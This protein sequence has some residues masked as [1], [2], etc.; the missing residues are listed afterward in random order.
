MKQI[1]AFLFCLTCSLA[2]DKIPFD[3]DVSIAPLKNGVEVWIRPHPVPSR[4][5]AC[6]V[7]AKHPLE[8]VPQIFS[9]NCP[10]DAFEEELPGFVEDCQ[11]EILHE[12]QC[13]IA[14]IV[15][16]D[17]KKDELRDFLADAFEIFPDRVP[18]LDAQIVSVTPSN[19]AGQFCVSL[20][21]PT[22]FQEIMTDQ[23]LKELWVLYLLQSIIEEKFRKTVKEGEGQWIQ[24]S[25]AKYILP[26]ANT[27]ARIRQMAGH[28]PLAGLKGFLGA[29]T[30]LK[31]SGFSGQELSDAKAKLQKNLLNFY[32]ANPTSSVLADFFASHCAFGTGHPAYST[33]M[34]LSFEAIAEVKD[35]DIAEFI[36]LHFKDDTRRIEVAIPTGVEVSKDFIS[37]LL[38]SN[39]TDDLKLVMPAGGEDINSAYKRLPLT[40]AEAKMIYQIIDTVGN[41]GLIDLYKKE[42]EITDLGVKVQHVH[43]FKFLEVVLT[44]PHLKQSMTLLEGSYFKWRGFFDG[45]GKSAG[46]TA[47]CEREVGRDNLDPYIV[48]FCQAVKANPEQVR[49][50]VEKKEWEKLVRFLIKLES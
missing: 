9:L 39:K 23:D 43:P 26:Y 36:K 16:G 19:D 20:S 22:S 21:Y 45:S 33:F 14:V 34:K 5:I 7:I 25:H 48:G 47:K 18:T 35:I 3:E 30:R 24:P 15:V 17:F 37:D 50:F 38:V 10:V 29:M 40:D 1:L 32:E 8:A 49:Y 13:K 4:T 28:D 44:N 12:D 42:N 46:F 27:I 11:N 31:S 2:A 41:L 6:R